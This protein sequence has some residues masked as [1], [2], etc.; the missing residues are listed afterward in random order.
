MLIQAHAI[1]NLISQ[2]FLNDMHVSAF[3]NNKGNK[4]AAHFKSS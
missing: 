3:R 1:G 4:K 2:I